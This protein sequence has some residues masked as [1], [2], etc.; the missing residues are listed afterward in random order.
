MTPTAWPST[1]TR[2]AS[3]WRT[4]DS[5]NVSVIDGASNTV[6]ATVA[7]GSNPY[8]VAVNPNTNRIYVANY[9]DDTVS[10][11]EDVPSPTPTPTR[12]PTPRPT[13][14]GVGGAVMLPPAAI[15][16]ESGGTSGGFGPTAATFVAL[17]G[18]VV[19]ALAMGGYARTRR[20]RR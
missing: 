16:G 19:A 2:T 4:T 17:A 20:R 11:I 9:G 18:G 3:T 8:G 13:A 10:V 6:V 7:V 14:H 15:A 1:P 12:T 5:N